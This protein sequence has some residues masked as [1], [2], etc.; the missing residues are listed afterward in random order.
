MSEVYFSK[1]SFSSLL[2]NGFH[3]WSWIWVWKRECSHNLSAANPKIADFEFEQGNLSFS[4]LNKY[5]MREFWVH[6]PI[7]ILRNYNEIYIIFSFEIK[8]KLNCKILP[9]QLKI[10][11]YSRNNMH[12]PTAVSVI[13]IFGNELD[14]RQKAKIQNWETTW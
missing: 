3:F 12:F 5:S 2:R 8:R 14:I 9:C 10:P 13:T 6:I 11:Y 7:K 1:V 4:W